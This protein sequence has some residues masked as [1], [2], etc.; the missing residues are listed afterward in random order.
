M[1]IGSKKIRFTLRGPWEKN[2]DSFWILRD[3]VNLETGKRDQTVIKNQNPRVKALNKQWDYGNIS[4]AEGKKNLQAIK[5]ELESELARL[6]PQQTF[7]SYNQKILENYITHIL[8]K[9]RSRASTKA[10]REASL[11]RAVRLLGNL[12]LRSA[13]IEDIQRIA[14]TIRT[15]GANKHFTMEIRALLRFINREDHAQLQGLRLPVRRPAYL[16]KEQ[17]YKI[18]SDIPEDWKKKYPLMKEVILIIFNLGLRHSEALALHQGS[19]KKSNGYVHVRIEKQWKR[20]RSTGKGMLDDL[21][22]NKPRDVVPLNLEETL[23]CMKRFIKAYPKFE[24]REIYRDSLRRFIQSQ[25]HQLFQLEIPDTSGLDE[26][27][28]FFGLAK[29]K[30]SM[31]S[32]RIYKAVHMLRASFVIAM[33]A[34]GFSIEQAAAQIGDSIEVTQKHYAG[35][36]N[37]E[38]S[39]MNIAA[40]LGQTAQKPQRAKAK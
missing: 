8:K 21:K 2:R 30:N 17:V 35:F 13:P 7:S 14:D 24:D 3:E 28:D 32:D 37:S 38:S 18:V 11:R 20:D 26:D 15:P 6:I 4:V 36:V 12:S 10:S 5:K 33:I 1:K 25:C 29:H 34:E 9:R 19:V 27:D 23:E 22:N 40:R 31:D 39:M 16:T